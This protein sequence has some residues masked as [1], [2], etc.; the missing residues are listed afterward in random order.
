MRAAIAA[1]FVDSRAADLTLAH[2]LP[3]WPALAVH[4]V[5]V[6]GAVV[7][8]RVLGASHQV[9]LELDGT[10]DTGGGGG[11]GA[12][13]AVGAEPWSE[14]VACVP[15]PPAAL[16]ARHSATTG[17]VRSRLTARCARLDAGELAR[18]V[19]AVR[20]G[21]DGDASALVAAFPGSPLAVTALVVRPLPP[22]GAVWRTWHAYPQTGELVTTRTE[23]RP[24]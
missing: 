3:R 2:G 5:A 1:P 10:G 18:R 12:S 15:D 19:A 8:L 16:P 4:R 21:C 11:T 17:A 9:V 13:G 22:G 14:T 6:P 24:A 7:E 23:A 20:A